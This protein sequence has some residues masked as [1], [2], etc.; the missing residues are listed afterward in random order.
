MAAAEKNQS[1][2]GG[3]LTVGS[4][5][6]AGQRRPPLVGAGG[7]SQ[8]CAYAKREDLQASEQ[9]HNTSKRRQKTVHTSIVMKQDHPGWQ[10]G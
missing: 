5:A 4:E 2:T 8:W 3:P 7:G 1:Q 6:A 10:G 9:V